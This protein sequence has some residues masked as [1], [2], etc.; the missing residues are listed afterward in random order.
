MT[1]VPEIRFK[2]FSDAWE[3]R[4]LGEVAEFSKG[5]GYSKGDL[6]SKG[7]PIILYGRL[8]TKYETEIKNV[9]TFVEMK[10]NSVLSQGGE[11]IVPSS[12]ETAEDISRASVVANAG[13]ILGGDL[14]IVKPNSS[15]YPPF[16]AVSISNGN[17]QKEL[18][19]RAQGKSVV[20][21]NNSDLKDVVLQTPCFNE[22]K[23]LGQFFR[24]LDTTITLN[25]RKLDGLRELKKV[26]LQLMFPQSCE[27]VPRVRFSG[28]TEPWEHRKLGEVADIF[29]GTHQTPNYVNAGIMFLSVENINTLTSKKFI[30]EDD[31]VKNFKTV[32]KYGDILMTRIGDIGTANVVRTNENLA[33]YVSL[34]LLKPNNSDADFLTT[35]IHSPYVQKEIW[36]RTLHVAFPKKINLGEIENI[37]IQAPTKEEQTPIGVFFRNLDGQISTQQTKLEKL[38]NLKSAYLQKMFI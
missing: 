26:Y 2:G 14:N 30:S 38:K 6:I 11:V 9:D 1:N 4:K 33:Y 5:S 15:I 27:N 20:H 3:Q 22:Q 8:Y 12:G 23:K 13:V 18:S 21:I 7:S 35:S 25:K 31:Y 24:T 37:S 10:K 28:F 34:A 29:D 17:Q 36:E 16:L 32:P 19:R